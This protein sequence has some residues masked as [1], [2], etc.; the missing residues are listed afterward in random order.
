[1]SIKFASP[2]IR[3]K[4][5]D[6]EGKRLMAALK[7]EERARN[8]YASHTETLACVSQN[9]YSRLDCILHDLHT[10]RALRS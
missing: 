6:P 3:P 1:M 7:T 10:V 2:P 8:L 9:P 5:Q 4:N